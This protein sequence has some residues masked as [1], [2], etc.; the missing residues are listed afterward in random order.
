MTTSSPSVNQ[1]PCCIYEVHFS[2]PLVPCDR[3]QAPAKG[4]SAAHRT[5][6]DINLDQPILL[7]VRVSVHYCPYCHHY[8]RVQP[9][10]LRPDAIYANRVVSK[11]V[12]S[13]YRDGMAIRRV[14]DRLARDFWVRPSEAMIRSWC[15]YYSASFNFE[16]DYQPWV[17]NE[18]SGILCVDEVYQGEL[19]LLLG[20]DPAAPDGD[21]LVGYELIHG[22]VDRAQVEGFL[23]RI[24]E[25]GIEPDQVIT[26]GSTLYPAVLS[27]LWPKAAHQL[28]LF[29]ETRRVTAATMKV[30]QAVRK[31]LPY[32]PPK[33]GTMGGGPLLSYPPSDDPN[34]PATQRWHWRQ[35]RRR[36]QIDHVRALAEKGLSQRAISRQTGHNRKTVTRWL[37]QDA[38]P[39]TTW[40]L[41]EPLEEAP[42]TL[43]VRRQL[44][45]QSRLVKKVQAH[46]LR[47]EG[48]SYCEI[49]R[50]M[51]IH[52]VTISKWLQEDLPPIED[53]LPAPTTAD[54]QP[55]PPPTPWNTWDQ[56]RQIREALKEHR[57]LLL[58]RPEHLGQ[59]DREIVEGLL[60]SPAGP[61][62]HT[63]RS[64]LVDWYRLWMDEHG[65]RRTLEV[66]RLRYEAWRSDPAYREIP[67]LKQVLDRMTETKFEQ[68][69]QFLRNPKWEATNNGAERAGRAFRH[70]QA[71]HFNLRQTP[72]VENALVVNACLHKEASLAPDPEP[73]HTCQRGRRRRKTAVELE[74]PP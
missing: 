5:G 70:R 38:T 24:K 69:S 39:E 25:V 31:S 7:S 19:A 68:M 26:D 52:R 21:R 58:R 46:A 28:C 8:F 6:I 64:F 67:V 60:G 27:K 12:D 10:F 20:V 18:F 34:D 73:V 11:A 54:Y 36:A 41:P 74:Q 1:T 50:R 53:V 56:V 63:A 23:K 45:R 3:C 65:Q 57:F 30:I 47:Q 29:H 51:G 35:A 43:A 9:P 15:R 62:L 49:A 32:P 72:S 59:E 48:L 13:V 17:V 33:P 71:P 61:Q 16:T 4:Y 2:Q 37:L 22:H 42:P 55:P 44:G 14:A 66:A 40:E